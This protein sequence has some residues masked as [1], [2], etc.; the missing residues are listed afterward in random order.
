MR[1]TS[2][3]DPSS[4]SRWIP[5]SWS[6]GDIPRA[7]EALRERGFRVIVSE[8]YTFTLRRGSFVADLYTEPS[9]A[10]VVYMDRGKLLREYSEEAEVYRTRTRALTREAE[11]AVV[12]THAVYKE[13]L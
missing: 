9:F 3:G 1:C 5:T 12:A 11:V 4:T 6:T 13:H 8:P 2:L 7:V 10:W